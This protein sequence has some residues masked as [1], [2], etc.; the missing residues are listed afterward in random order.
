MELE[1]AQPFKEEDSAYGP[2]RAQTQPKSDRMLIS[3]HDGSFLDLTE[4]IKELKRR[5]EAEKSGM[6]VSSLNLLCI[7]GQFGQEVDGTQ[8]GYKG[9]T[10][11]KIL[12]YMMDFLKNVGFC[13]HFN[14]FLV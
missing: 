1:Q 14:N 9:M 12:E 5:R 13:I 2:I 3:R 11:T 10:G 4:K 6:D 7:L 8:A